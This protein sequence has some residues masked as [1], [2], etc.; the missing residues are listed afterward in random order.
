[1]RNRE[2]PA[3]ATSRR[4]TVEVELVEL[5][6]RDRRV[7]SRR[8]PEVKGHGTAF[9]VAGSTNAR[10]QLHAVL[11][12]LVAAVNAGERLHVDRLVN[13]IMPAVEVPTP[14]LLEEARREAHRRTRILQDFGAFTGPELADLAGSSAG[15]RSS[16]A[17]R[18]KRDGLVFSVPAEGAEVYPTFQFGPDGKPLPV[19]ALVLRELQRWPAWD[20]AQW[21]VAANGHLELRRP[22][23]LLTEDPDAVAN[24]ARYDAHKPLA[25]ARP[26]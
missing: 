17:H 14:R 4:Q 2:T 26:S 6:A 25:D 12:A 9:V 15:N 10:R 16:T 19:V 13:A 21:F 5:D 24:A 3:K 11:D 23:E 18:W 1:V 20:I 7:L 22:V 8:Y